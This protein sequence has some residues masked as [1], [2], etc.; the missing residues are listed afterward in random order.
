MDSAEV[1]PRLT[2]GP[3]WMQV[4]IGI[5]VLCNYLVDVLQHLHRDN[6]GVNRNFRLGTPYRGCFVT[7]SQI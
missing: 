3:F 2:L 7:R 6:A 4:I 5:W 1:A